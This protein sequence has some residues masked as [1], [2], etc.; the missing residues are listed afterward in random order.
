M[1]AEQTAAA[2]D[3]AV[4]R[5]TFPGGPAKGPAAALDAAD[6]SFALKGSALVQAVKRNLARFPEDFMFQLTA[7]EWAVL[8]SQIV[9][10]TS[11]RGARGF[12]T[13]SRRCRDN[14]LVRE[15]GSELRQA[16]WL[17][18]NSR[19][20]SLLIIAAARWCADSIN[21]RISPSSAGW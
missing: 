8:R 9:I 4:S 15:S 10:P 12:A 13:L 18:Q 20:N 17:R 21:A 19:V 16:T 11:R 6:G 2:D 3:Q 7:A 5:Q 14:Y 1:R